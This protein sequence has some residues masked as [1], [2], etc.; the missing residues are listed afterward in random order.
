MNIIRNTDLWTETTD[1]HQECFDGAFLDGFSNGDI[2]FDSFKIVRNCNCSIITFPRLPI[3][4]K[5]HAVIFYKDGEPVRLLVANKD[6]NVDECISKALNQVINNELLLNIF[7]DYSITSSVVD[8]KEEPKE[9][10]GIDTAMDVSSSDRSSLLKAMLKGSWTEEESDIG[11]DKQVLMPKNRRIIY[12][13]VTDEEYFR[14][15][16][17]FAFEDLKHTR[18]IPVQKGFKNK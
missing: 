3:K 2:P 5:H 11:F 16:H 7:A 18:I 1:N 13:L 14:I 6:T 8:M 10:E 9:K 17:E 12:S 4:N 15:D